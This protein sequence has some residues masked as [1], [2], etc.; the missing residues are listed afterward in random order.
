MIKENYREYLKYVREYLTEHH[1]INSPNPLHP[2]RS[3]YHHTIRVLHW[4][5]RLKED[6]G[7]NVDLEALYTAAI[8]HDIGYADCDN[9]NH[10]KRSY[11]AFLEYAKNQNMDTVFANKVADMIRKHSNK[12][13]LKEPETS[14][15][16][17]LLMEA[18]LLDEEG[19]MGIVWDCMTL[20]NAHVNS[21]G[22]AYTHIMESSNKPEPNP[23]VTPRAIQIWEHKKKIAAEF[24]EELKEDLMIGSEYFD[25]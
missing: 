2:F 3:R 1:G 11:Q 20:G 21:Y 6:A 8:F 23:M 13:L 24:A 10:A 25:I 22:N 4:C 18:D 14:K 9:E 17:I 12:E 5:F 19:A 16:L 7:E 15:E